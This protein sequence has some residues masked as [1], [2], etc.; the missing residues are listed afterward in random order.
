VSNLSQ[1]LAKVEKRERRWRFTR[2]RLH[3]TIGSLIVEP[4]SGVLA[5]KAPVK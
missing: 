3:G 2:Y 1:P 5:V 4:S